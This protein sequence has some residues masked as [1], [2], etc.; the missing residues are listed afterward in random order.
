MVT[1]GQD[2]PHLTQRGMHSMWKGVFKRK[3]QT[4]DMGEDMSGVSTTDHR[5]L[6]SLTQVRKSYGSRK[7]AKPVRRAH[8]H[9]R[10]KGE[11]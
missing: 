6:R 11:A 5:I 10:I 9:I 1:C 8:P 4:R 3:L 7:K 2:G